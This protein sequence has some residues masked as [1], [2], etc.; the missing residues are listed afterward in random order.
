[1]E[2][3]R[4]RLTQRGEGD[5]FEHVANRFDDEAGGNRR[6]VIVQD[7]HQ[8]GRID[9]AVVDQET[10]QLGVPI[11]LDEEDAVV[12]GDEIEHVVMERIGAHAQGV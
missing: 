4:Q 10:A 8:T 9:I 7:R 11:L 1:M 2:R 3:S 5:D 6:S 12:G